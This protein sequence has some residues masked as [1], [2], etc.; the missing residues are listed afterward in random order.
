M[1]FH[2]KYATATLFPTSK[3]LVVGGLDYPNEVTSAELYIPAHSQST[4]MNTVQRK[5][6]E[7]MQHVAYLP[8]VSVVQYS[9]SEISF[10]HLRQ[11]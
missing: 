4:I 11:C 10:G 6:V 7:D 5:R 3:V 8:L 1:D 9:L 2:G